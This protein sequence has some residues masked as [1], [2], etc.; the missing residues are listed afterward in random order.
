MCQVTDTREYLILGR[1]KAQQVYK[2]YFAWSCTPRGV[3]GLCEQCPISQKHRCP[4]TKLTFA[5]CSAV[6]LNG[7]RHCLPITK[8]YLLF[9][10]K[11]VF[12]GIGKLPGGPYRIQLKCDVQ[13]VQHPP[14]AVPE[15][16]KPALIRKRTRK[17]RTSRSFMSK[18]VYKASCWNFDDF[19]YLKD[20]ASITR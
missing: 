1:E 6:I 15:K 9:E 16:K 19:F 18:V 8:E 17:L 20:Q 7:N 10:Y 3:P 4:A 11:D 13:P 5:Y 2:G 14:R 12:E